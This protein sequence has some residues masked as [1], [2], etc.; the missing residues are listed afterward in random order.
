[1]TIT[2]V[3]EEVFKSTYAIFFFAGLTLVAIDEAH[4]VSQWGHDFRKS[5]RDLNIIKKLVPNVSQLNLLVIFLT[6]MSPFHIRRRKNHL[7]LKKSSRRRS[8]LT[9]KQGGQNFSVQVV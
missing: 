2:S 6:I 9:L 7:T 4:C 3:Y 8:H 1:M 5:Y